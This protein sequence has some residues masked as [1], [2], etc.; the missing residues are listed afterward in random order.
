MHL[1]VIIYFSA[2]KCL[3]KDKPSAPQVIAR[4]LLAKIQNQ[5][6]RTRVLRGPSQRAAGEFVYLY[7]R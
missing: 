2:F 1:L 3:G 7:A 6:P 4:A 5:Q